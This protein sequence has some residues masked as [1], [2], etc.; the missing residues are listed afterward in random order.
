MK[1]HILTLKYDENLAGFPEEPVRQ[2]ISGREVLAV[3]EHFFVHGGVP[4]LLL[5]LEL[6]GGNEPRRTDRAFNGP[7]VL[8]TVPQERRKLYLDLKRWR[9]ERA[10][11]DGVPPFVVMRNELLADLCRVAPHSLAALREIPGIGEKT[12]EKYGAEVIAMIPENLCSATADSGS[13]SSLPTT[14]ANP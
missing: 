14:S 8:A 10:K 13:E 11:R 6:S 2:A 4:H 12:V 1:I 9:N 7:D 3:R 5:T